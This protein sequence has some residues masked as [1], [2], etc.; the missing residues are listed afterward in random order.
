[1]CGIVGMAGNIMG[2]HEKA[3]KNMLVFD[4]V[5]GEDSTGILGV[6]KHDEEDYILAKQVGNPFEVLDTKQARD[7]FAGSSRILLGHNRYATQGKVN[8]L[9]AHPF[10]FDDLCGVHNGTLSNKYDLDDHRLFDVDSENLY[11]CIQKNGLENTMRIVQGAWALVWWDKVDNTI[12]FLRNKE[13]PLYYALTE[14]KVMTWASEE[15]MIE[16]ALDR[17][18]IKRHDVQEFEVGML[19]SVSVAKG[20]V[21]DKPV[22]RPIEFA[23]KKVYPVQ[24]HQS[25][26][27]NNASSSNNGNNTGSSNVSVFPTQAGATSNGS[28]E[29]AKKKS[30]LPDAKFL[31]AREVVLE[32][33]TIVKEKSGD[34][35]V[36][37]FSPEY[38]HH[39]IRL[40]KG[41]VGADMVFNDIGCEFSADVAR[42]VSGGNSGTYYTLA[43]HSVKILTKSTY[44][45]ISELPGDEKYP[46]HKGEDIDYQ[47]WR[48]E[49]GTCAFCTDNIEPCDL[50]AGARLTMDGHGFCKAC[51]EDD[52]IKQYVTFV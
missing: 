32:S 26:H 19:Y 18:G 35:Y 47:A 34:E 3:F 5:R 21:L 38:P 46:N 44:G 48:R 28:T 13:R 41:F 37:C 29:P 27:G 23:P 50:D 22:V 8:K 33:V 43:A 42:G 31:G 12:N 36:L 11:H 20:G 30:I 9:N 10:D 17:A 15:W 6:K 45:L 39:D 25:Y 1:M 4:Y 52:E 40:Y 14:D 49:Y 7:I 16:I 51:S 2:N 24:Q